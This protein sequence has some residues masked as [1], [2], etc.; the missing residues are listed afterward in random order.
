MEQKQFSPFLFASY[1]RLIFCAFLITHFV[2]FQTKKKKHRTG[3]AVKLTLQRAKLNEKR[4]KFFLL[5]PTQITINPNGTFFFLN[6]ID[7]NGICWNPSSLVL[8]LQLSS[9]VSSYF[10]QKTAFFYSTI[11]LSVLVCWQLAIYQG[12][13]RHKLHTQTLEAFTA[14]NLTSSVQMVSCRKSVESFKNI[15]N[16]KEEN[17]EEGMREGEYVKIFG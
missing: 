12:T 9:I 14:N 15:T 17:T 1:S 2:N 11:L 3:N 10:I 8:P 5:Q 6:N 16:D 4:T 13:S 7:N